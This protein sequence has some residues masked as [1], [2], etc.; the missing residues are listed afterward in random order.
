MVFWVS[1]VR[2]INDPAQA[3]ADL[4]GKEPLAPEASGS[5]PAPG[6]LLQPAGFTTAQR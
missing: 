3:I 2:K 5:R 1:I 6:Q 4:P